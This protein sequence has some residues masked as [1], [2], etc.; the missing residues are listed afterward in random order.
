[1]PSSYTSPIGDGVSFERFVLT[2][3]RAFGACITMLDEPL[4]APIPT[5]FEPDTYNQQQAEKEERQLHDLLVLTDEEVQ[6]KAAEEVAERRA[7]F[8]KHLNALIELKAKYTAMLTKV[9]AWMPPSPDHQG[10]KDFMIKQIEESIEWDCSEHL[11]A[12]YRDNIDEC[13][14]CD[15]AEW[16]AN[17]ISTLEKS[18]ANHK[19]KQKEEDGRTVDRSQWVQKLYDS[20]YSSVKEAEQ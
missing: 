15:A 1:M 18:I 16:K 6:Q 13:K 14:T 2:C 20:L 8:Q 4:D 10:L 7:Y 3:A 9:R 5:R 17:R 11:I 19:N 12:S